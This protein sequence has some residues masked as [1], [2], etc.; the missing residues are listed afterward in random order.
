M[1]VVRDPIRRRVNV[2]VKINNEFTSVD[3]I[4]REGERH[5][6][7]FTSLITMESKYVGVLMELG[8]P[9]SWSLQ[10]REGGVE[11]LVSARVYRFA[12]RVFRDWCFDV[13]GNA[14]Q[15]HKD[16]YYYC[17]KA[18]QSQE[19]DISVKYRLVNVLYH[20]DEQQLDQARRA[21][22]FVNYGS[23]YEWLRSYF[24]PSVRCIEQYYEVCRAQEI[25]S[26]SRYHLKRN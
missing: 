15:E 25:N 20:F 21:E 7:S 10:D 4:Y 11:L 8:H 9:V 22:I 5:V 3:L 24:Q 14:A 17:L 23:F 16:I 1:Y 19:A 2:Q 26:K 18:F 13:V 6:E 12:H